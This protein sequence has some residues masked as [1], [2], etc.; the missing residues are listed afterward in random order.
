MFSGIHY[1]AVARDNLGK[2]LANKEIDI[3]FSIFSE[4][5]SY[6]NS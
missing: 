3:R 1:Q 2:E 4:N 5:L 6:R